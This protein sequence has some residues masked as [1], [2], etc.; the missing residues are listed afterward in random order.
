M[1]EGLSDILACQTAPG[2][3]GSSRPGRPQAWVA[4]LVYNAGQ[5]QLAEA[6][7]AE[8]VVTLGMPVAQLLETGQR[9]AAGNINKH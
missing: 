2:C 7:G 3:W 9:L 5:R 8:A 4:A 1:A 6:V